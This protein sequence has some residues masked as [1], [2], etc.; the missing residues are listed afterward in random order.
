MEASR[1]FIIPTRSKGRISH[2]LSFPL[3]AERLSAALA[4]V[5]QLSDLVLHFQ[6]D[7]YDRLRF[8]RYPYLSVAYARKSRTVNPV[9]SGIPL[10]NVWEIMVK[11]VRRS[12]RH[13]IQQHLLTVALPQVE[14]WLQRR[15]GLAQPGT[16]RLTFF[17]DEDSEIFSEESETHLEPL[18]GRP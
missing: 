6:S 12:S 8:A 4:S 14:Q 9:A 15:R 2:E 5:P 13:T 1:P 3:G 11:P 18:R 10:F 16:D 7:W 17:Y